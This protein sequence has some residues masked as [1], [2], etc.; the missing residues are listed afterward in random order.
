MADGNGGA[1]PRGSMPVLG[2]HPVVALKYKKKRN[3][4]R[5]RGPS[6]CFFEDN[7]LF[8]TVTAGGLSI[9]SCF[10]LF[11]VVLRCGATPRPAVV[12]LKTF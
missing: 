3:S 11:V 5:K 7:G 12:P 9:I 1:N 8:S 2:P 4:P 10:C 6:V